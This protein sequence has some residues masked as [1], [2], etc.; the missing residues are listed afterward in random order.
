MSPI[1]QPLPAQCSKYEGYLANTAYALIFFSAFSIAG[2]SGS[3]LL[4]YIFCLLF[5]VKARSYP[6]LPGWLWAGFLMFPAYVVLNALWQENT[7]EIIGSFRSEFRL[8]IPLAIL[9]AWVVF[10]PPKGLRLLAWMALLISIYGILQF[11]FDGL[12]FLQLSKEKYFYEYMGFV[13]ATGN[14]TTPLTFAGYLAPLIPLFFLLGLGESSRDRLLFLSAS[15]LA[16]MA[17]ILSLSRSGWVGAI[18]G[19]VIVTFS[20]S[21]KIR[22]TLISL[23]VVFLIGVSA[24]AYWNIQQNL[25]PDESSVITSRIMA[26]MGKNQLR[27]FI[28]KKYLLMASEHLWSGVGYNQDEAIVPYNDRVVIPEP[29]QAHNSA[30]ITAHNI[31]LQILAYLGVPGLLAFLYF[32]AAPLFWLRQ[33]LK[34]AA[35]GAMEPWRKSIL[36]G[37]IA[38]ISGFLAAGFFENNFFDAEVQ[39]VVMILMGLGF[40]SVLKQKS[41]GTFPG[42]SGK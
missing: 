14:F 39:T 32:W 40:V 18:V 25:P 33:G 20:F 6:Q 11:F 12:T 22:R 27:F 35:G 16:T 3:V 28:W 24:F 21:V 7:P 23:F 13:R 1:P 30:L 5:L 9:P 2:V 26:G 19:L 10:N 15:G 8:F 34:N 31:Y 42:Q 37:A 17:T 4:L 36:W 41:T 38:G 29:L